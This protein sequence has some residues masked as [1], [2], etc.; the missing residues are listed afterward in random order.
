MCP[1]IPT[2]QG[3]M[4]KAL[5]HFHQKNIIY[6]NI[7]FQICLTSVLRAGRIK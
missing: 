5:I 2:V 6:N 7:Y 1:T 4:F 3:N